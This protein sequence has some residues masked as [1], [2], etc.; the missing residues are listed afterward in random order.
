M[1]VR[2][3]PN[4]GDCF[5]PGQVWESPRGTLYKVIA[6][7]YDDI[8]RTTRQ[9]VLRMGLEGTGRKLFRPWDAVINWRIYRHKPY[10]KD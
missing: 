3:N 4:V 5:E 6:G 7:G 10:N 8:T 2:L 1:K 9:A